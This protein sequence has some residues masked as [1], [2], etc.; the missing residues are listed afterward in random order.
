MQRIAD[1]VYALELEMERLGQ[2]SKIYP[3]LLS[4]GDTSAL[5][6]AGLPTSIPEIEAQLGEIG[7]T[8][9]DIDAF[10]LTHQD[11][12]HIGGL[13]GLVALASE[14]TDVIC[15]EAEKS[16]IE[17]T[18]QFG[19]LN[20][21]NL[22]TTLDSMPES[23]RDEM[24]KL[25]VEAKAYK[26]VAVT[27]T[28]EDGDVLP[29]GGGI[30]VI[31]TPGHTEGH[32]C[33]YL[34]KNGILVAGDELDLVDGELLG[35]KHGLSADEG[36]AYASISKLTKYDIEDVL[37]YHGGLFAGDARERI[38]GLVNETLNDEER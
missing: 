7:L 33:L 26:G 37:C 8:V 24:Q 27:K 22:K 25:V 9:S 30:T 2:K 3:L 19:K 15:H 16:F 29:F 36:E 6:D 32:I 31:H 20:P 34:N 1:G 12:D 11:L 38:A 17:G 18:E 4:D 13:P 5:I 35:P 10:V 21:E 14:G 28:V 23:L